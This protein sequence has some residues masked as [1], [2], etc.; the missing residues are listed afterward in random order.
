[1]GPLPWAGCAHPCARNPFGTLL[2]VEYERLV[3]RGA[4]QLPLSAAFNF[5]RSGTIRS[6]PLRM[7]AG[8]RKIKQESVHGR[9]RCR[10]CVGNPSGS[11][12][13]RT[14]VSTARIGQ[15]RMFSSS[16]WPLQSCRW[17]AESQVQRSEPRQ[18]HPLF[19]HVRRYVAPWQSPRWCSSC[20]WSLRHRRAGPASRGV[21]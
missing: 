18:P 13:K 1:M 4:A 21:R 7:H 5:L 12:T 17:Y 9:R 10:K 15:N 8:V 6:E 11:K 16:N 14:S 3:A 19:N 2:L 20:G